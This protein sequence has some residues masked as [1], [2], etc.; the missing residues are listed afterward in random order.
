MKGD[1]ASQG[2]CRPDGG[3]GFTL[4]ED[5]SLDDYLSCEITIK[6]TN[7]QG[8]IHQP[9]LI[10]KMEATFRDLVSQCQ[11][12]ATPGTP[13]TVLFKAEETVVTKEEEKTYRSGVG[14]LLYL[15]KH[16]RPDITNAVKELSK[17]LDGITKVA[18]KIP[19]I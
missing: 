10:K 3:S 11:V 5:G 12:Y 6:T 4:K 9:H 13:R 16:S 8:W 15:V 19:R 14:Q 1:I 17:A 18:M 2:P 7:K